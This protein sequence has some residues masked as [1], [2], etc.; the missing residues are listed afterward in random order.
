MLEEVTRHEVML[1]CGAIARTTRTLVIL[2]R[3]S[4]HGA[5]CYL[6]SACGSLYNPKG[7]VVFYAFAVAFIALVW[8][9]DAD[10]VRP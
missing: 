2:V 10:G 7:C 4:L 6:R 8:S 5:S 1:R 9:V 3:Y